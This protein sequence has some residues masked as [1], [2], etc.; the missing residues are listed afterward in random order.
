MEKL[1]TENMVFSVFSQLERS[2][3]L[4]KIAGKPDLAQ[5][6]LQGEQVQKHHHFEM[7]TPFF[8]IPRAA[9]QNQKCIDHKTHKQM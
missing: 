2:L 9:T 4:Q 1:L 6:S 7:F 5:H 3:K 8:L